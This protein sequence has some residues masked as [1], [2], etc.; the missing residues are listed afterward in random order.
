MPTG[1]GEFCWLPWA[2]YCNC[3]G[4]P[5]QAPVFQ[6]FIPTTSI[7]GLWGK[8]LLW[9]QQALGALL[10]EKS[11]KSLIVGWNV[12]G[13][14]ALLAAVF[15]VRAQRDDCRALVALLYCL[16]LQHSAACGHLN[17][18]HCCGTNAL[19]GNIWKRP[20][21]TWCRLLGVHADAVA[22]NKAARLLR[23]LVATDLLYWCLALGIA[24]G[25][26]HSWHLPIQ[27]L[28]GCFWCL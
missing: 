14:L 13:L 16:Q 2:C 22:W 11:I 9:R 19:C 27:C 18:S 4:L 25:A 1:R 7:I 26:G 5:R 17:A 24:F 21:I 12:R 6:N 23:R 20:L 8:W 28:D 15:C 3:R 10:F